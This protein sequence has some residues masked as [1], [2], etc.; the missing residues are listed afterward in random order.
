MQWDSAAHQRS[1]NPGLHAA[2]RIGIHLEAVPHGQRLGAP[3]DRPPVRLHVDPPRLVR[4]H[5]AV[6][7]D[8]RAMGVDVQHRRLA[9]VLGSSASK[10]GRRH[11]PLLEVPVGP[12]WESAIDRARGPAYVDAVGLPEHLQ[13]EAI[14][15]PT[16][17][18]TWST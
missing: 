13:S 14:H 12:H 8:Q 6:V 10:G 17:T 1:G 18:T 9:S 11:L 16:A 3:L 2:G 5:V 15:G 4:H 7:G